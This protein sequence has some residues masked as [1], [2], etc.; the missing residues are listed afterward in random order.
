[1]AVSPLSPAMAESLGMAVP[2]GAIFDPPEPGSPAAAAKIEAEDVVTAVNGSALMKAQE[3]A[4]RSRRCRPA[5]RLST[6][7]N[8]QFM[9]V[10]V[11][12]GASSV[13][14]NRRFRLAFGAISRQG[15]GN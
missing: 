5:G 1:V 3:F 4:P 14:P 2:Y 9:D 15:D 13:H 8:G 6:N 11:V 7:R 12:L 10:R